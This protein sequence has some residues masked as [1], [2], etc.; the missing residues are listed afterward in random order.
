MPLPF[1]AGAGIVAA[2][3]A[4]VAAP[5]IARAAAPAIGRAV[6]GTAGRSGA[7][8]VAG[9][10]GRLAGAALKSPTVAFSAG[11]MSAGGGGDT[12]E[13]RQDNF[14]QGAVTT[15]PATDSARLAYMYGLN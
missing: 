9:A 7:G 3:A 1:I 5:M 15:N 11:R 8:S 13:S 14:S 6:A 10:A 12:P 4:R 2:T